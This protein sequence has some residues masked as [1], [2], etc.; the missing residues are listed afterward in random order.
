MS[1]VAQ[2][3]TKSECNDYKDNSHVAGSLTSDT[4]KIY[5]EGNR[6]HV[7]NSVI[8]NHYRNI[9]YREGKFNFYFEWFNQHSNSG[10][11]FYCPGVPLLYIVAPALPTPTAYDFCAFVSDGSCGLVINE[12]VWHT[13]PIPIANE[14][15][16]LLTTQSRI[17]STTDVFLSRQY[18][19]IINVNL[20]PS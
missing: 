4:M 15:I 12:G 18:R 9:G 13:N 14:N 6:L 17:D 2:C 8:N 7:I 10:Q 16:S 1:L 20:D 5:W 11:L 3:M 19:Q